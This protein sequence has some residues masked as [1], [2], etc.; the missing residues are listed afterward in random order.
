MNQLADHLPFANREHSTDPTPR[1]YTPISQA[2]IDTIQA[3]L[4]KAYQRPVRPLGHHAL[5]TIL[6]TSLTTSEEAAGHTE[7]EHGTVAAIDTFAL[8]HPATD[9]P[10]STQ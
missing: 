4:D 9:E 10:T 1:G 8:E 6:D 2:T 3:Q 5:E 7:N